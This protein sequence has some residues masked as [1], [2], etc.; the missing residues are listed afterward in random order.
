LADPCA[1]REQIIVSDPDRESTAKV[2]RT[3]RAAFADRVMLARE[4][5]AAARDGRHDDLKQALLMVAAHRDDS[6]QID[7]RIC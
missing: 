6:N 7:G 5:V 3:W 4:I 1:T 2:L